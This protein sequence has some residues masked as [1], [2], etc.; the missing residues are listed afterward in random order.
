MQG[1]SQSDG[2][3]MMAHAKVYNCPD[4]ML[5][6]PHHDELR[7]EPGMT[8]RHRVVG[9]DDGIVTA[10]FGLANLKKGLIQLRPLVSNQLNSVTNTVVAAGLRHLQV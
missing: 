2:Y 4:L 6:Y 3:Q 1:V 5:L 8:S 10:T 7:C 9:S